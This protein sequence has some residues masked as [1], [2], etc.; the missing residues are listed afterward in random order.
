MPKVAR[1]KLPDGRVARFSVPDDAT[2]EQVTAEAQKLVPKSK[3]KAQGGFLGAIKSGLSTANEAI[4]GAAEGV[5]NA[6]SAVTDPLIY[7]AAKL[8]NGQGYADKL[9]GN[10]NQQ[11]RGVVSGAERALVSHPNPTART[12]GRIG[13]AMAIPLPINKLQQG[14]KLAKAGARAIQ[15]AVGG[16]AVREVDQSAATPSAIGAAANVALP[17]ILSKLAQTAPAQAVGRA[18][19][20]AAA[21]VIGALDNAA[22]RALPGV[23]KMIGR[24]SVPLPGLPAPAPTIPLAPLGRKAQARDARFKA[25]GVDNPTTGMVTRD[26]AA[27]SFEQNTAKL[28]GVGDDLANQMREVETKLVDK[29]RSI[30]R[31]MGGAKGPEATGKAVED[32]LDAKRAEMQQVTSG[33]YKQVREARGDE[34]VGYLDNLREKMTDPDVVDNAAFDQMRE[35]LVRRMTRLGA[36]GKGGSK[37]KPV[38][39]D[40]AEELRKFIGG[41][42]N[43]IEPGVRMMRGRLIEALDDDVVEAVGDDAFKAA[44]ASA[45]ARFQEFSK[46]FPG[47]LA[48]EK[49]APEVLTRRILG[50]GV[51]LSDLRALRRSLNTGTDDQIARGAGAWKDLQA[52]AVDDLLAK[53]VDADGNLVGSTLAREFGKSAPKFRE[54]L[55]PDEFKT[56]RRLAAATRDVKAFPVGHSVNTSNTAPTLAN[57]FNNAPAALREGW[58]KLAGKIGMRAGAHAGAAAVAGPAGNIAVESARAA[59]GAVAAQRAEQQAVQALMDKIKLAQSP[60]AAAAAIAELQKA[61]QTSPAAASLLERL[62]G[63][64]AAGLAQP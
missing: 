8:I 23:N 54:I 13:G 46:T 57:M 49:L 35:G 14:G 33:L 12:V 29:G 37:S 36:V 52:Q 48:D 11:R 6:G 9:A 1:V 62:V 5:Y 7:Q 55:G 38:T 31:D 16:A 30:V 41:L 25:L 22:E 4:M 39:I 47:K 59:G 2:P 32:V 10:V 51:K 19:G 40:Q 28:N 15:G 53:S 43:N 60:E 63:G 34:P 17:P 64:T 3:P 45:R 18:V 50:D 56:L 61:A 21:P 42:G 58:L 26:P 24:Q 27:F 20:R 44:R